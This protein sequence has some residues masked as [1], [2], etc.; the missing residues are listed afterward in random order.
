MAR[1]DSLTKLQQSGLLS[2]PW[3]HAL[4]QAIREDVVSRCVVVP[5][6][7]G[8]RAFSRGDMGD[9]LFCIL[10]GRIRF[11]ETSHEGHETVIDFNG[12]GAWFG[13]TAAL[14][15]G[16]RLFDALSEGNTVLLS[17]MA[18]AMEELLMAHPAFG[19]GM[20]QL[21]AQRQR[22]LLTALGLFTAMSLEQRLA[23]RLLS[24]SREHG[25]RTDKGI[26]I[27]LPLSQETLAKLIGANRQNV[28]GIVRKWTQAGIIYHRY[29]RIAILD[30]GRLVEIQ[31]I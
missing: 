14:D 17:L 7:D 10:E 2:S 13:E 21:I 3:F 15:K 29:K 26:E 12:P 5:L 16:P 9:R 4:D 22:L 27:D 6:R 8:Q 30:L 25:K 19:R 31:H 1:I 24:L 18:P 23:R 20:L 28:N 11:V